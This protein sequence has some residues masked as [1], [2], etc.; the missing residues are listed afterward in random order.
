MRD[1]FGELVELAASNRRAAELL[2]DKMLDEL[3]GLA[4]EVK[5]QTKYVHDWLEWLNSVDPEPTRPNV[6]QV[7]PLDR[8]QLIKDAAVAAVRKGYTT[9]TVHM[10]QDMF[11]ATGLDLGVRQPGSVI[12]TVLSRLPDFSRTNVGEFQYIGSECEEIDPE[13]SIF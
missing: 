6:R 12:G 2:A 7:R 3:L 13:E 4:D 9:V 11:R 10:I 8:P 1:Y 5:R